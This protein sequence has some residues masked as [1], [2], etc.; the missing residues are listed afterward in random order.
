[1]KRIIAIVVGVIL[2]VTTV[3]AQKV[4]FKI[5]PSYNFSTKSRDAYDYSIRYHV[6]L[7]KLT[8][9]RSN[10]KSSYGKGYMGNF[11]IGFI[12][13]K[14]VST[15]L[16]FS[17]LH[18]KTITSTSVAHYWS[19]DES[20]TDNLYANV[21]S[22]TPSLVY[23]HGENEW[24]PYL[25]VGV[26]LN[27]VNYYNNV[28]YDYYAQT[29]STNYK[30]EYKGSPSF[31]FTTKLGVL[32]KIGYRLSLFGEIGFSYLNFSP[33]TSE[34][35]EY[36]INNQ[37]SIST[38]TEYELKAEYEDEV[39]TEYELIDDVFVENINESKPRERLKFDIPLSYFSVSVGIKWNIGKKVKEEI[40]VKE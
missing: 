8:E 23:S 35:T 16:N 37:D 9:T 25:S 10:I 38:L 31:G 40:P 34:I 1:M 22:L 39:N 4:Y 20:Y 29:G 17:Y 36:S 24:K 32:S 14:H 30:V 18:G 3:N 28:V 21:I 27:I 2:F 19:G 33:N 15:E 26:S 6:G 13:N 11:T 7:N 12:N 5:N